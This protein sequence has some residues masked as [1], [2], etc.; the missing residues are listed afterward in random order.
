MQPPELIPPTLFQLIPTKPLTTIKT[1]NFRGK[2]FSLESPVVM[3]I[4]NITEDSFYEASRVNSVQSAIDKAGQMLTEGARILDIGAQSTR[5][6]ASLLDENKET[7]SL[8]NVV[9]ELRKVFPE[10]ILSVDTF[11]GS[12]AR[13]AILS[14]ADMINDIS[15]ST[16]DPKMIEVIAEFKVPYVLMHMQGQ[17]SDMHHN[18]R[19]EHI[20]SEIILFLSRHINEL[21]LRGIKDIVIDPGFGFGKNFEQNKIL[22]QSLSAFHVLDRPLLVGISR[23]KMIQHIISAPTNESLNGTTAAHVIALQRGAN[24]LRVHDVKAAKE[25]IQIFLALG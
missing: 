19:Y 20:V 21:S 8:G 15:A 25:A 22:F 23:K 5:P 13:Q 7:E 2:L 11:Y 3:G 4:L 12:V 6:G 14:G 10:A 24:I 9:I 1:L 17:P 16:L 18:P